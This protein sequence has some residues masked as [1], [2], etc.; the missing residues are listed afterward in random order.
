MTRFLPLMMLCGAAAMP[1]GC[2]RHHGQAAPPAAAAL[3]AAT[4]SY[5]EAAA[6]ETLQPGASVFRLAEPGTCPGHFDIRPSQIEA[7]RRCRVLLRFEF[8][9]SIDQ[10]LGKLRDQGLRTAV[11]RIPGGLCEPDSYL[12][13]CRQ[14]ADTLV[15]AGLVERAAADERL[16]AAESRVQALA[17]R[18]RERLHAGGWEGR[19]VLCSLHQEAFCR[20]LGLEVAGTFSGA[21]TAS[22]A[23]VE[24]AIQ[25]GERLAAA[26]VIANLPE[27]RKVA[28]A[29]GRRL[30]APVVVFGNFPVFAEDG[31]PPF[32]AL[33]TGNVEA[34]L[35]AGAAAWTQGSDA[36]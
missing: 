22:I 15:E 19:P 36:S 2:N 12:S 32:D 27:G 25:A 35:A 34:L 10:R 4:N 31:M 11:I 7:L 23:Q 9:A 30:G 33:V 24:Q 8:Q 20:W 6:A 17:S 21:D 1:A 13:A 18:C 26:A 28:D 16:A 3:V 14:V 29:L 5:L